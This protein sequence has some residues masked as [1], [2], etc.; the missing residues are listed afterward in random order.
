MQLKSII[1]GAAGILAATTSASAQLDVTWHV[2]SGGGSVSTSGAF[3]LTSTIGQACAGPV[4][5]ISIGTDA[6]LTAGFLPG[7]TGCLSDFNGDFGVTSQDFFDFLNAF[8]NANPAA[9]LDRDGF[10]ASQ[11]FF[12]FLTA[13]FAGC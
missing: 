3:R 13:F 7:F 11:D 6:E 10:V 2:I 8:F 4:S 5:A 9:D 12:N 1:F